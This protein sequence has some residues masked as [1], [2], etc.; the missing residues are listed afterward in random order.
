MSGRLAG[1]HASHEQIPRIKAACWKAQLI[2]KA[3][4]SEGF[5]KSISGSNLSKLSN[6]SNKE[7][8]LLA[9]VLLSGARQEASSRLDIASA[10]TALARLDARVISL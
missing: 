3:G 7:T 9:E 1:Q 10:V 4:T 6:R 2:G 8:V 5:T